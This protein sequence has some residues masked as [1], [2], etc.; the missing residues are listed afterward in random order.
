M[1]SFQSRTWWLVSWIAKFSTSRKE[2]RYRGVIIQVAKGL[3]L[4]GQLHVQ[5][6]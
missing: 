1:F 6:R 3:G 4:G 5:V 2:K